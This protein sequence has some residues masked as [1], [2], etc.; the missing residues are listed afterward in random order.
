MLIGVKNRRITFEESVQRTDEVG[1]TVN[2]W[3]LYDSSW[4]SIE[5]LRGEE[6][7]EAQRVQG[8]ISHKIRVR[9]STRL[10]AMTGKHRAV[11][12]G[13]IF[14]LVGPPGDLMAKH[15]ELELLAVERDA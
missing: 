14:D 15:R 10:A 3:V 1:D 5:P 8:S 12:A 6:R 11:Y 13:R 7:Y 2:E 4:A 9:Y